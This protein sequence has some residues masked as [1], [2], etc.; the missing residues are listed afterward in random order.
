MTS[1]TADGIHGTTWSDVATSQVPSDVDSEEWA[2]LAGL[3]LS[4]LAKQLNGT[5]KDWMVLH[6]LLSAVPAG[7][8]TTYGDVAAVIGSHAVRVGRHLSA[9]G[10][11]PSPWRVLNAAGRVSN[12][13]QWAE[14][15]RT[16]TPAEVLGTEGVRFNGAVVD[17]DKRLGPDALRQLLD[18]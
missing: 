4:G 18:I 5:H 17:A 12:G 10:Q 3:N 6:T 14:Q 9:R 7:R 15:T 2:T 1:R 16:D 8:W 11:C 13:F